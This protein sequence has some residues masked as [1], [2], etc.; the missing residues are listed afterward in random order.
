MLDLELQLQILES[1]LPVGT[2]KT[3]L[4]ILSDL[5]EQQG[6]VS[7]WKSAQL[8]GQLVPLVNRLEDQGWITHREEPRPDQSLYRGRVRHEDWY[9]LTEAGRR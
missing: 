6:G 2:E 4:Q 1:L 8:Y 9:R 3:R 7:W 5:E